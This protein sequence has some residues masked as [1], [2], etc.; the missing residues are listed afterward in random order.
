MATVAARQT[1]TPAVTAMTTRMC[2]RMRHMKAHAHARNECARPHVQP[3]LVMPR[4]QRAHSTRG[5]SHARMHCAPCPEFNVQRASRSIDACIA[6]SVGS[7]PDARN[8]LNP[9][10][11]NHLVPLSPP[12]ALNKPVQ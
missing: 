2:I 12:A 4:G 11:L 1:W 10:C 8:A 6:A 9:P 3:Q 5:M 7:E